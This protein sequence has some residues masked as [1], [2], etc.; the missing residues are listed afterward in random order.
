MMSEHLEGVVSGVDTHTDEHVAA[1]LSVHRAHPTLIAQRAPI[2]LRAADGLSNNEVA[3]L[4]SLYQGR[5]LI[6]NGR[7]WR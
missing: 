7:S 2:V 4:V 3:D 5:P 1:M 6:A